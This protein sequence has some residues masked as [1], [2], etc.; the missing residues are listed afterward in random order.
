MEIRVEVIGLFWSQASMHRPFNFYLNCNVFLVESTC[1]VHHWVLIAWVV[2]KEI[3]KPL[4]S[5]V[6][7]SIWDKKGS[8]LRCYKN[9][10]SFAL[11]QYT[12]KILN[13]IQNTFNGTF[14]R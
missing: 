7:Y 4:L 13:K 2:P 5:I 1:C 10:V 6:F 11:S 14:T 8:G 12:E 3:S 9:Q